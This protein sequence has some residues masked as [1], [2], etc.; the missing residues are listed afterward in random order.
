MDFEILSVVFPLRGVLSGGFRGYQSQALIQ[1]LAF[2]D[3]TTEETAR[4]IKKP[5]S[6]L[7]QPYIKRYVLPYTHTYIYTSTIIHTQTHMS[8]YFKLR[9]KEPHI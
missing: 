8:V 6:S 4:E 1:Y 3:T 5:I 2:E 7:Y 9:S